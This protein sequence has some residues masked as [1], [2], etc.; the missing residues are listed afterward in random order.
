MRYD[1]CEVAHVSHAAGFQV[2]DCFD[3]VR[4]VQGDCVV[5]QY[6]MIVDPN[7]HVTKA[8]PVTAETH[9]APPPRR[10]SKEEPAELSAEPKTAWAATPFAIVE[11]DDGKANAVR[12]GP[13]NAFEE[14]GALEKR[15]GQAIET[16]LT[17]AAPMLAALRKPSLLLPGPVQVVAKAQRIFLLPNEM[18]EG[19]FHVDGDEENVV[20][21]VL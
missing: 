13:V 16:I 7:L 21:V 18:Y 5:P 4:E 1:P 19:V 3:H 12:M 17:A 15:A 6:T 11:G 8:K 14:G 2:V 10:Y 20:A 9:L